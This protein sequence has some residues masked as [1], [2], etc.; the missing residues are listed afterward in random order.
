M[1]TLFKPSSWFKWFSYLLKTD[2]CLF[3]DLSSYSFLYCTLNILGNASVCE[4]VQTRQKR[5][6]GAIKA[7]SL[8]GAR[9]EGPVTQPSNRTP[10]VPSAPHATD[11][12]HIKPEAKN[13]TLTTGCPATKVLTI[14]LGAA[15]P[16][17]VHGKQSVYGRLGR[18]CGCTARAA[19]GSASIWDDMDAC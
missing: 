1:Y 4:P 3:R 17:L 11:M 15:M 9:C 18:H 8:I 13:D 10:V 14:A 7:Q 12:E 16:V 6:N 5:W 2:I 19:S